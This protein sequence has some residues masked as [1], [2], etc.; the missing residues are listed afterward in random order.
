MNWVRKLMHVHV[1]FGTAVNG[2][3]VEH[4]Q[5]CRCGAYRHQMLD[6]DRYVRGEPAQ[7]LRGEHP[8][9]HAMRDKGKVRTDSWP[10][11]VAA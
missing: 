7:W 10:R 6:A 2:Y 1:W 4:E 8:G 3:G 11:E 9:A 5:R